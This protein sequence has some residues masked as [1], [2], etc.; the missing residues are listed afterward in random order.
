MYLLSIITGYEFDEMFRSFHSTVDHRTMMIGYRNAR[1]DSSLDGNEYDTVFSILE[2]LGTSNPNEFVGIMRDLFWD[3][4]SIDGRRLGFFNGLLTG[5]KC[6][7]S[8]IVAGGS[9]LSL[10]SDLGNLMVRQTKKQ[11]K[12]K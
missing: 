12:D 2:A 8:A 10:N 6:A 1:S 3:D 11:C 4:E 9:Y 5:I 7:G